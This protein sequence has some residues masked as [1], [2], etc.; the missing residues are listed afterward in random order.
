[1]RTAT[2]AYKVGT[3][4]T[5]ISELEHCRH[6]PGLKTIEAICQAF[7]LEV[8]EAFFFALK[9]DKDNYQPDEL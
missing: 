8:W 5:H 7:G 9:G 2:L 4:S 3:T 6:Q 1:M